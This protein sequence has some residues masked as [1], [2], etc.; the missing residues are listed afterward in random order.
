[1]HDISAI[2]YLGRDVHFDGSAFRVPGNP[3]TTQSLRKFLQDFIG[4]SASTINDNLRF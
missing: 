2:G 3:L 4:R 1:M